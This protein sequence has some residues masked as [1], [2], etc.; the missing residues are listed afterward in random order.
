MRAEVL[1]GLGGLRGVGGFSA[2]FEDG[3]DIPFE[4]AALSRGQCRVA[5][6]SGL[7]GHRIGR[8]SAIYFPVFEEAFDCPK[9]FVGPKY[10]WPHIPSSAR[11]RSPCGYI[12]ARRK[13]ES[14]L[15]YGEAFASDQRCRLYQ[16]CWP[17]SWATLA[18]TQAMKAALDA[19]G[20]NRNLFQRASRR[21][22]MT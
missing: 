3:F 2:S 8:C 20:S 7:P 1:S 10:Q 11:R 6:A 18:A 17:R 9:Q 21:K 15:G 4:D 14:T 12:C 22:P 19:W 5:L 16:P 13:P